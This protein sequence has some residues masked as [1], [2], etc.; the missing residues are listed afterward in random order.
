MDTPTCYLLASIILAGSSCAS[1]DE[2][3]RSLQTPANKFS[4]MT[5]LSASANKTD[6]PLAGKPGTEIKGSRVSIP[7]H[8]VAGDI[9]EG[10]APPGSYVEAFDQR[11]QVD[12]AGNFYLQTITIPGAY[13]I[14]VYRPFSKRPLVIRVDLIA[15]N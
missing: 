10:Q 8:L 12:S 7:S 15:D 2:H 13:S 14:R 1:K 11:V 5:S 4:A 9:L 6:P 3:T